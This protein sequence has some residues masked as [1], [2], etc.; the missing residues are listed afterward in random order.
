MKLGKMITKVFTEDCR[1]KA[2][3][4]RAKTFFERS[5]LQRTLI[6]LRAK[7]QTQQNASHIKKFAKLNLA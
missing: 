1:Q 6:G 7:F 5:P 4:G 2:F 3:C